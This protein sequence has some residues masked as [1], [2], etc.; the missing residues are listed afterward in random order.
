M[1]QKRQ[2]LVDTAIRPFACN[3]Y[4]ATGIDQIAKEAQVSKKTM[5]HHFRSKEELI[6]AALRHHDGL[7]RNRFMKS[8]RALSDFPRARPTGMFDVAGEW[9]AD[10]AFYGCMFISAAGEYAVQ[11][12]A[13]LEACRAYKV[14]ML[15][16]IRELVED[17]GFA[18]TEQLT[19]MLALLLEGSI[20]TA[21][22]T[23]DVS[24]AETARRAA[25]VLIEQAERSAWDHLG[26]RG[27]AGALPAAVSS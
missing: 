13:I 10:D 17:A 9:F 25:S 4:H 7:F 12:G 21:Q 22:V 5:Y 24:S 23:G 20:V 8:V 19:E 2:E 16:F 15:A 6:L 26:S 3:G 14:Q 27:D 1:S 11:D 18:Q